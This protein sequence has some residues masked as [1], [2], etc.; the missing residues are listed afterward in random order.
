MFLAKTVKRS[1]VLSTFSRPALRCFSNSCSFLSNRSFSTLTASDEGS[2]SDFAPKRKSNSNST[3]NTTAAAN[4]A[5]APHHSTEAL[6]AEVRE[7]TDIIKSDISN[8]PVFLYMKG[9]PAQPRCGF[10]ANVAKILQ[11]L[12]AEFS[13]RDVLEN[14]D[15]R[16]AVKLYSDWPTLPQL[17]V[18]G[19]FVG[20]SDIVTNLFKSGELLKMLNKAGAI[21]AQQQ[22]QQ[23]KL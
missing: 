11:H 12:G 17:Y 19:E 18:E 6:P 5:T 23:Q 10:S 2:H 9:N 7:A 1:V 21:K 8:N 22:Q 4:A 15:L 3:N 14:A 20:G 16:E 13:S